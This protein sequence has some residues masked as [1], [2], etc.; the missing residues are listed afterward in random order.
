M[1]HEHKKRFPKEH[2]LRKRWQ[3]LDVQGNGY[4]VSSRFFIGLVNCDNVTTHARLG[5]TTTGRY[6]N[7]V[8]R[9]WTKRIVREAFRQGI[10]AIPDGVDLVVIPKKHA[11]FES[12]H[13]IF[14]DL[15]ALG[16]RVRGYVEKTRC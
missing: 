15:A 14:K 3:Y 16:K 9:N 11:L 10:M 7:A 2:R 5:I 12:S 1:V 6:A 4:K 13:A 8:G